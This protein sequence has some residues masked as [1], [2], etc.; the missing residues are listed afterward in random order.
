[1]FDRIS[2]LPA[3]PLIVHAAVVLVPL[4]VLGAILYAVAPM[5]RRHTRWAV[6]LLAIAAPLAAVAAKLSGEDLQKN[7]NL[8][9][10]QIQAL[11]SQHEGYGDK[12]MWFAIALGVVVL[13]F[14]L[15]VPPP[16]DVTRPI[17]FHAGFG[18]VS[19]VLAGFTAFYVYKTGDT[20]AHMVWS[21]Y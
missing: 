3:H 15:L 20:G 1:M 6:A 18:L 2:G 4:L 16:G 7:K 5:I 8:Q 11:I 21:G 14:V 10:P 9:A 12:T 13:A 19:V 17:A